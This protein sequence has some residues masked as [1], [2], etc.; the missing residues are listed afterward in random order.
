MRVEN[1]KPDLMDETFEKVTIERLVEAAEVVKKTAKSKVRI[2]TITR[3]VYKTGAKAGKLYTSREPERLKKSIRVVRQKTKGG[4]AFSKK[5]NVRIYAG[6]RMTDYH[7]VLEFYHPFLRN[8][9]AECVPEIK[10]ILG[11]K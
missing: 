3:P 10:S 6:H 9:L 7:F 2:G 8:S 1:W 5:R 4:K 11:V